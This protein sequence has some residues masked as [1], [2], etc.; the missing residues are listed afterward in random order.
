MDVRRSPGD[1]KG[2]G[3]VP[4]WLPPSAGVDRAAGSGIWACRC[5][6]N[7]IP[8]HSVCLEPSSPTGRDRFQ[9][10][11]RMLAPR[12]VGKGPA[13]PSPIDLFV[14]GL[15]RVNRWYFIVLGSGEQRKILPLGVF[16]CVPQ[17]GHRL[18]HRIS[19]VMPGGLMLAA[20]QV[21]SPSLKRI[22]IFF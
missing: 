2:V 1:P 9:G 15:C 22:L 4:A 7:P 16:F 13:G 21:Q 11:V 14:S 6:I 10:E 19:R 17:L 20:W 12:Q 5:R 3:G 8:S 18:S